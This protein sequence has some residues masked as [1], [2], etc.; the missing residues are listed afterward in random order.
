MNS[1]EEHMMKKRK[2]I[3]IIITAV[4][5]AVVIITAAVFV[6]QYIYYSIPGEWTALDEVE[7][8]KGIFDSEFV[9]I[10]YEDDLYNLTCIDEDILE[11]WHE[12]LTSIK[13]RREDDVS[14]EINAVSGGTSFVVITTANGKTYAI[15][16]Y[17]DEEHALGF[18]VDG[19]Y[20]A[21]DVEGSTPYA[22]TF[23]LAAERHGKIENWSGET[24]YD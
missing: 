17:S 15:N 18:E 8:Y 9:S 19:I 3:I 14:K 1:K 20:Y 12:Y 21:K 13:I 6:G 11:T 7:K 23:E 5:L 2:K 4:A 16:P 24:V 10:Y 22:E